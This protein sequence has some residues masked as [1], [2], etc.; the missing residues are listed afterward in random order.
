MFLGILFCNYE[1]ELSGGNMTEELIKQLLEAGVHFGHQAKRWNPKMKRYIFGER[2]GIYI[3]DLE[4]TVEALNKARDFLVQ[5]ASKGQTILFVGTKKQAQ[6]IIKQEAVRCKMFYVNRRWLGGLMTNFQTIKKSIQHLKDIENMEKD[7]LFNSLSKKEV[8]QLT[9][10]KERLERNLSG[11]KEIV[12]LPGVLFVVDSKQEETA[13]REARKL[14]MPI[15]GLI[16]TNCDPDLI[17]F[18]IPGNDDAMK[19]IRLITSLIADSIIEGRKQFLQGKGV[20]ELP[21]EEKIQ[22]KEKIQLEQIEKPEEKEKLAKKKTT[23]P[24]TTKKRGRSK[25]KN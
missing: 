22:T 23:T 10:E 11:I 24:K 25:I 7:G 6:D 20:I 17:D 5:L 8:A 18:P 9:K 16:D 21:K 4:K 2:S 12:N 1:Q 15:V 14:S 13:V 19:S 3:I